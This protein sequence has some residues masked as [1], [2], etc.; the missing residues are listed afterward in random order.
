MVM[1][2]RNTFETDRECCIR[3]YRVYGKT[4]KAKLYEDDTKD[5]YFHLYFNP[6][7]QAAEREHLEQDLDKYK[8]YMDK[9]KGEAISFGRTYEPYFVLQYDRKGN[10]LSYEERKDVIQKELQLCGYFCIIT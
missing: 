9:H 7:K 4:V 8:L 1:D 3:S 6:S 2:N 5:R 10:F